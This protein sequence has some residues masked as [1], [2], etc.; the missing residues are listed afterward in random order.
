MGVPVGVVSMY[1]VWS[2]WRP[3][4]AAWPAAGKAP[5]SSPVRTKFPS[6]AGT[7]QSSRDLRRSGLPAL[8]VRGA[9]G[10]RLMLKAA[11]RAAVVIIVAGGA[12]V[13]LAG[14]DGASAATRTLTDPGI[15]AVGATWGTAREV[16]GT[17]GLN[18]DGS[19]EVTIAAWRSLTQRC[20]RAG[21]GAVSGDQAGPPFARGQVLSIMCA[22]RS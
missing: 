2:A 16:P 1:L 11:R 7:F 19:A 20:Y 14:A 12:P 8:R 22:Y 15:A 18:V 6:C 4:R 21:C 13:A 9:T 10:R 5:G 3:R 17:A